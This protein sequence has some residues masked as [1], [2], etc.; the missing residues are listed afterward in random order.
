MVVPPVAVE[1]EKEFIERLL[2]KVKEEDVEARE[3]ARM[4]DERVVAQRESMRVK[5]GGCEAVST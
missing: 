1:R 5:T 3:R 4:Q 2:R